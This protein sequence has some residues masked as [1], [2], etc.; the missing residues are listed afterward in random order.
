MVLGG[1]NC[2]LNLIKRLK[3]EGDYIILVDYLEDCPAKKYADIHLLIS[4]F[5]IPSVIQ[6]A[7]DHSIEAIVTLGTDQPVLTAATVAEELG[8][9]FY[10]N[11]EQALKATNKRIMKN[12]FKENHIPCVDYRMI[13]NTFTDKDIEGLNFPAVLKPVD[14]QGQRGIY[15]VNDINEVRKYIQGTLSYSREEKVLLEEYYDNDEITVNGYLVDGEFYIISV[16]DRVTMVK[17]NHIGICICHNFQSVHLEKN[18]EEILNITQSIINACEFTDGPVYF[19]YLVGKDGIKVNEIA[20][21][22][23]GAYEDVT[24]PLLSEID[25]LGLVLDNVKGKPINKAKLDQYSLKNNNRYFS[26]QL[27][28]CKPGK[29]KTITPIND[30]KRLSGVREVYYDIKV[31]DEIKTIE[32]ATARA[33]YVIVSGETFDNMIDNVN[34]MFNNFKVIDDNGDNLV[35]K[36]QD[37]NEKYKFYEAYE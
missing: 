32:N 13:D 34:K 28:F 20:M 19:Q 7:K 1:G 33:G 23:G 29:I 17:D 21:R 31:G 15:K 12:I 30:L 5:D 35:I 14:S 37:Y 10:L 24:V 18:Y 2:Q 11:R 36:Y 8:L 9:P 27:F 16:V 22:I 4:T 25:I 26:A 3:S 6:A